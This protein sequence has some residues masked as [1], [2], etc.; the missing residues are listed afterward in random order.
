MQQVRQSLALL[1]RLNADGRA[2]PRIT[3]TLSLTYSRAAEI[4]AQDE[5]GYA[6]ALLLQGNAQRMI[7]ALSDAAPHNADLAHLLAF[8]D[9]DLAGLLIKMGDLDGAAAHE[10][11]ALSAFRGLAAADP[12]ITEYRID[13]A[14]ALARLGDVALHRGQPQQAV[15]LLSSAL[16]EGGEPVTAGTE[17]AYFR[18]ARAAQLSKLGEANAALGADRNQPP[19]RRAGYWKA[20]KNA[21]AAALTIDQA[22]QSS[23]PQTAEEVA[24]IIAAIERCD[25]ASQTLASR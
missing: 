13:T 4:L 14:L 18:S 20:A 16:Q 12:R 2:D 19:A 23:S 9:H 5:A 21:F 24:K 25:Q 10:A 22:L 7:K 6:E 15:S 8:T 11:S 17:N 3:R 1:E